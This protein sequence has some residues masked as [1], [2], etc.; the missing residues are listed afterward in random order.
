V[1]RTTERDDHRRVT[2]LRPA[3]SDD[4]PWSLRSPA[5][6]M[7]AR[8]GNSGS[9]ASAR[10]SMAAEYM[11]IAA[12]VIPTITGASP[13]FGVESA[14]ATRFFVVQKD[15]SDGQIATLTDPGRRNGNRLDCGF[16]R[17]RLESIGQR[18]RVFEVEFAPARYRVTG[19]VRGDSVSSDMGRFEG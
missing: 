16:N 12:S 14:T 5:R 6:M 19:A 8:C 18:R 9:C 3:A 7:P 11:C 17:C 4:E 1:P 13:S 2:R 15:A 10:V